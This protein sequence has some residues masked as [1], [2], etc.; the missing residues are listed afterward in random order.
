[1]IQRLRDWLRERAHQHAVAAAAGEG[2]PYVPALPPYVELIAEREGLVTFRVEQPAE[3]EM[4][5]YRHDEVLTL[6]LPE[7]EQL[8]V[9]MKVP[10]PPLAPEG[11]AVAE[12]TE[13][14]MTNVRLLN[15]LQFVDTL[16][17]QA[18]DDE[19]VGIEG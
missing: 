8:P 11:Y 2:V 19:I 1:M 13:Q 16:T 12:R 18:I 15:Q 9:K 3:H 17:V 5:A 14:G 7:P 6:E 4:L 10:P